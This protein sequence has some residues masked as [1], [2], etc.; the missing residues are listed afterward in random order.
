MDEYKNQVLVN[1]LIIFL[2]WKLQIPEI[3]QK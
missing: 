2:A 1:I 3:L